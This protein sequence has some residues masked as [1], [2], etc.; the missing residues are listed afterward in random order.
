MIGTEVVVIPLSRY[1]QLIG[2]ESRVDV[3]AQLVEDKNYL[4]VTDLLNILGTK[5]SLDVL[6]LIKKEDGEKW[7]D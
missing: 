5:K 1:E 6:A 7:K 2:I 3:I 4:S